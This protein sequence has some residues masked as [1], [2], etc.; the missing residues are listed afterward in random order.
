MKRVYACLI[1][2]EWHGSFAR[3]YIFIEN[4]TGELLEDLLYDLM[5]MN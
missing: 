3:L 4:F 1:D 2:F 5:M